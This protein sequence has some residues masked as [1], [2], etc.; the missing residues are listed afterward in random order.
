MPDQGVPADDRTAAH[1]SSPEWQSFEMRMRA[2]RAERC[3][4]RTETAL[5][6]GSAADAREALD[7][8]RV[9]NPADPRIDELESRLGRF[10]QRVGDSVVTPVAADHVE[11]NPSTAAALHP[12]MD[13]A[14]TLRG[15]E[16][17]AAEI[18]LHQQSSADTQSAADGAFEPMVELD[19]MRGPS[20][21]GWSGLALAPPSREWNRTAGVVACGLLVSAL[22]GWQAWAHKDLIA[23]L[24]S[25]QPDIDAT[26]GL[27][28]SPA[29]SAVA[30]PSAAPET[31]SA[32]ETASPQPVP[33]V[34][35][36]PVLPVLRSSAEVG[37]ESEPKPVG[38]TGDSLPSVTNAA[39]ATSPSQPVTAPGSVNRE[40]IVAP[41]TPGSTSTRRP[42]PIAT[43]P[44]ADSRPPAAS[45]PAAPENASSPV[46]APSPSPVAAPPAAAPESPSPV[47]SG[48]SGSLRMEA[49]PSLPSPPPPTAPSSPSPSLT[50]AARDQS[51]AVRATLNRY[52]SAYS[53]LDV[54]AVQSVWPSLDQRALARAF[55]G[56]SSQ[57]VSLGTCSV[58][59]NG[60]A[61]R[62]DCSGSAAWIPKIGG[63][64]HITSR[65]WTFDL[66]ESDGAWRIVRVQAR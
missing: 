43:P 19:R 36:E 39:P 63:G 27:A 30:V 18:R 48:D 49:A 9:L 3:F 37:F 13:S 34:T 11:L 45:T 50:Y 31:V 7:E 15:D 64:E 16:P 65:K 28:T 22:A 53:R 51:A 62:A 33:N 24:P 38:S 23:P 60:S 57:R 17:I 5:K 66:T 12:S 8:A 4:Q 47:A 54:A 20:L 14:P 46:R 26:T 44:V 10:H 55:D 59:V 1:I 42:E 35:E 41:A 40:V 29:R 56:L 6:N 52:E 61:A 58:N 21:E 32:S 2:R 25:A